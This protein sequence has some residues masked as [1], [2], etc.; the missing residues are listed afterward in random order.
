MQIFCTMYVLSTDAYA[1]SC[2]RMW[3]CK[4]KNVKSF[5]SAFNMCNAINEFR[6]H[7]L[8]MCVWVMFSQLLSQERNALKSSFFFKLYVHT[9]ARTNTHSYTY[10]GKWI[11]NKTLHIHT[12]YTLSLSQTELWKNKKINK[13]ERLQKKYT[14]MN[15]EKCCARKTLNSPL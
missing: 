5:F 4:Y 9:H 14:R 2:V 8:C 13:N 10:N 6:A 1:C 12:Q 7:T 3:V 15:S 11:G